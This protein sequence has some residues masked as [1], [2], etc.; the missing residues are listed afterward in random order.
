MSS[1]I[2]VDTISEK[3]PA[4]GVTIDGVLLKDGNVDGV[5]VSSLASAGLVKVA[6]ATAS[7][8]SE[9]VLD[10]FVDNSLYSN[11]KVVFRNIS[12]ATNAVNMLGVF[13]SGGASG[14]D[15]TGTYRRSTYRIGLNTASDNTNYS[16]LSA[17]DYMEW[18][19]GLRNTSGPSMLSAVYDFFPAT[20]TE[21]QTYFIGEFCIVS[22]TSSGNMYMW[23]TN[24]LFYSSTACTGLRFYLGS[25]NITS[26]EVIVYGMK[27]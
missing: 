16:N 5:D 14:A 12:A 26:G 4:A 20:G 9:L 25:G 10:N 6:S 22:S 8:S 13:R 27:K 11:Y 19:F 21:G 2:K 3:T 17:T 18:A 23:Q 15:M 7:S 24:G 1:E